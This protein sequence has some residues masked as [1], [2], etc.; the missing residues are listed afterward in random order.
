[1]TDASTLKTVIRDSL[2]RCGVSL[3]SCRGH[4]YEGAAN[5]AGHLNGVAAKILAEEPKAIFVHCLAHS[6]NLCLQECGRQSKV[7]RDGLSLVNEICNFIRSSPKCLSLFECM[8]SGSG[9]SSSPCIET[10]MSN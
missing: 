7:I 4:P 5:M 10:A 9:M 2:I 1:M 3:S 6:V 8:K